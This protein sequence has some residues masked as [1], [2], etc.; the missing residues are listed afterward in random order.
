MTK[1]T[2]TEQP[3]LTLARPGRLELKKTVESGQVRQSFSHG[4]SKTVTVEVK[5]KRTF[6]QDAAGQMV[7]IEAE[8]KL[9]P[10]LGDERAISRLSKE[11]RAARE[12]A[13]K[14]RPPEAFDHPLPTEPETVE[15]ETVVSRPEP[16]PAEPEP[17][18]SPEEIEIAALR[19]AETEEQ[20]K[21]GEEAHRRAEEAA[22]LREQEAAKHPETA[23]SRPDGV[24]VA[25]APQPGAAVADTDA[26]ERGHRG[27]R[28]EQAKRPGS[29]TRRD[30]PRRR[31]AKITVTQALGAEVEEMRVRSLAAMRRARERE[32]QR[33]KDASNGPQ[34]VVREVVIPESI[35][36]GEL[37]NRM[38]A[39][40]AD[41]IKA[42]M[43][44]G[45]MATITQVVDPDTAELL[46]NEFGHKMRRV[47]ESDVEVGI[48]GDVDRPEE[49]RPRPPVVTVMGHVDHGKTSLL[50]AI[51]Q[52]TVAAHEA[53]GIT[54][55]I[56][57]YQV[58]LPS[59][60][61]IT[62]LDT[63][64][65]EAFS[66]MRARGAK[67]TDIV[68]LVVAADDSVQPQ[69]IEAINHAKAAKVPIIIAIN[70]IDRPEAN[71]Q[72]VRTDLLQH[73]LVTEDLGGDVLAVEVSAVKKTNIDKL[74]ETI[75]LQSELLELGANP[76]RPGQGT[77][78]EAK[79]ERGRGAVATVLVQRGT[80]RVGDV[81]VAGGEWGRVRAIL[82]E[83]G[84][85]I[86]EAGPSMPVEVLGLN[87][88]P[89]AGDEMVVVE[90]EAKA[91][92]IS[93]FRQRQD[94]RTRAAA[95]TRGTVEQMLSR[96]ATGVSHDLPVVI[97]ADVQGSVE[98]IVGALD[99]L[100]TDEV[101]VQMLHAGVGGI[102]ESDVTLASASNAFVI[103]F[104]VRANPQ[105]RELARRDGTD[106]RYYSIIYELV[107]DM[108]A[109]MSGLLSPTVR[110]RQIGTADIREVFTI[111]KVGKVAGC[112]VTDGIVKRGAG[113]RLLRDNVVIH[114]GKL[115][116]LKHFKDEVREVREGYECG[117]S[118]ET[119]QD[120]RVGDVIECYETDQVARTI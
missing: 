14:A 100:G 73:S 71:A 103:G 69:T 91:R 93:E 42:L 13:L 58:A 77:I 115:S 57:A 23:P 87:N 12:R 49:M 7:H 48:R 1:T 55:H 94:R 29:P 16:E 53:G 25:R 40:G 56:G 68:I 81:I 78:V 15:S 8:A 105:A 47:A 65:H 118:F 70:K 95:G 104:N 21:A 67:V 59:G 27:A 3:K 46:V 36:V 28:A 34:K 88:A 106:I 44:M 98:A 74:L 41:V 89:L 66:A 64:G 43:K 26:D 54:Q 79:L 62:F 22:R 109:A 101:R 82:D 111:T 51:R 20:R 90:N 112:R 117:M 120:I 107:D 38:A 52:T 75:Q 102:N 9:Q 119:Y 19:A 72:R 17:V 114:E 18:K 2:E 35:T 61:R 84:H 10:P 4:R 5:R 50:D 33:Q 116:T 86:A 76:N 30:E 85:N 60:E 96:I 31:S 99:K 39:R 108:R 92:E 97:K 32:R 80:L 37:A 113:V 63:P 83:H 6:T 24:M 45:V 11:E 110:E